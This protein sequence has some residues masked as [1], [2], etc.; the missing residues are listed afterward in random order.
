MVNDQGQCS[1]IFANNC[2]CLLYVNIKWYK[3]FCK[4]WAMTNVHVHSSGLVLFAM[5]M[6]AKQRKD[7]LHFAKTGKWQMALAILQFSFSNSANC[8]YIM[9]SC[10]V[11]G[12][13][14]K[15]RAWKL[16]LQH[17]GTWQI[18]TI[19]FR[20]MFHSYEYGIC[21][22][23]CDNTWQFAHG[24]DHFLFLMSLLFSFLCVF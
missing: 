17:M 6:L 11:H 20:F 16:H 2:R 7:K 1:L 14:C 23:F 21:L 22:I 5:T 19:M 10:Y 15:P 12:R 4:T 13:C 3:T 9:C 8:H 18:A 24:G